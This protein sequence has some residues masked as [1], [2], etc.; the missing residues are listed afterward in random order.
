MSSTVHGRHLTLALLAS[1][2]TAIGSPS[3]I[4]RSDRACRGEFVGG[5]AARR[6]AVSGPSREC[7]DPLLYGAG[8]ESSRKSSGSGRLKTQVEAVRA[9]AL[10]CAILIPMHSVERV[11]S[12]YQDRLVEGVLRGVCDRSDVNRSGAPRTARLIEQLYHEHGFLRATVVAVARPA[13]IDRTVRNSR[14]LGARMR[15]WD[16]AD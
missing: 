7:C 4:H 10:C 13:Q 16:G 8:R 1:T 12:A 14:S 3:P 11:S 15:D 6:R 9:G 2:R 5:P